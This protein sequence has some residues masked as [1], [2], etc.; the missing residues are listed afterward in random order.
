MCAVRRI[1]RKPNVKG[2]EDDDNVPPPQEPVGLDFSSPWKQSYCR[3]Y[4]MIKSTLHILHPTM[5]SLLRMSHEHL[6]GLILINCNSYRSVGR[7]Q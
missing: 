2:L 3:N 4:K 7:F 6:S 5:Q 1:L